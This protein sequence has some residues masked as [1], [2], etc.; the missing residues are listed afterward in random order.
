MR[1]LPLLFPFLFL[2]LMCTLPKGKQGER[3]VKTNSRCL[4]EETEGA[5]ICSIT[6]Y[7]SSFPSS[8]TFYFLPV[9]PTFFLYLF[10]CPL[11]LYPC[12]HS[13]IMFL[14]PYLHLDAV[15][16]SLFSS[17]YFF[18]VCIKTVVKASMLPRAKTAPQEAYNYSWGSPR[19][20]QL[21]TRGERWL[22]H[23]P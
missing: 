23:T 3:H 19:C 12:L 7:F 16:F 20:Q 18:P 21:S 14:P 15:I 6:N 4:M 9:W 1:N 11:S 10:S 8:V 22:S 2:S 17:S 5:T 13:F